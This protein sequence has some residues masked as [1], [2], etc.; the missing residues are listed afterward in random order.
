M[1]SEISAVIEAKFPE[2]AIPKGKLQAF[3]R[4]I[5]PPTLVN[6][7]NPEILYNIVAIVKS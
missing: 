1:G 6:Y 5:V 4:E 2:E 7:Q 3:V